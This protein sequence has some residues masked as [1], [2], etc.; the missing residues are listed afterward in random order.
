MRKKGL[1]LPRGDVYIIKERCKGCNLCIEYC[2][3]GVLVES[4]EINEK[5]YHIP[6]LVEEPP[7]KVCVNCE[8]CMYICPEFA[9]FTKEYKEKK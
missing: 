9:I 3:K 8:Y 1:T 6:M 7:L 2:P 5:G 4:E